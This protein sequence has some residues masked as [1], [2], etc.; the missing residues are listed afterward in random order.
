MRRVRRQ[1]Q[2]QALPREVRTALSGRPYVAGLLQRV[3]VTEATAL[4][5]QRVT[6]SV[7][8]YYIPAPEIPIP[9]RL[10]VLKH[11]ETFG[12][13]NDSGDIDAHARHEE[14][15]YHRGTRFLSQL[16]LTLLGTRPLLLSSAVHRDNLLMSADLTNPDVYVDDR[17]VL[18]RGSLH[19][20][21]S[22]LIYRDVCHER[23]HVRN[24]IDEPLEIALAIG[25]SA[26]YADIFE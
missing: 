15:L 26:D 2:S 16:T 18:P 8:R 1:P 6:E 4:S 23:I 9:E 3:S 25:F 13:F 24:F 7:E 22:K 5:P 17:V 12:L 21:R 14:G 19:V 11:D 20:Y 10:R